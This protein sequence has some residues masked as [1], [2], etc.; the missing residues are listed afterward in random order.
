LESD[1]SLL[2]TEFVLRNKK[3]DSKETQLITTSISLSW[4]NYYITKQGSQEM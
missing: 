2:V 4:D 3:A 1:E